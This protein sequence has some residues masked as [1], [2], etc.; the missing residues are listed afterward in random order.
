MKKRMRAVAM[1]LAAAMVISSCGGGGGE[2]SQGGQN[3]TAGNPSVETPESSSKDTL[4]IANTSGEPGN[5]QACW[6][7]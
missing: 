1:L 3:A 6:L 5:I 2:T 7:V 4:I